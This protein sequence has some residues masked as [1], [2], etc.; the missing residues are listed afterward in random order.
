[1]YVPWVGLDIADLEGCVEAIYELAR[2]E[3]DDIELPSA[4]ARR[5][6][7][8][9][10]I[11]RVANLRE[12][13]SLGRVHG[14]HIIAVRRSHDRARAEH[15]IGHELGHW[16]FDR[17]GYEGDDLEACCDFIGAG[18]QT[19]RS[20]FQK[21]AGSRNWTQLALDFATTQTLVVLRYGEV[22]G[23]PLV[24]VTPQLV[25]VRG[26]EFAWPHEGELRRHAKAA[27]ELPGLAKTRLTDD[28]RRIA[29]VAE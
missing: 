26:D 25:R 12:N 10:A 13:A 1:M 20:V 21:H 11:V 28:R 2:L 16:Y 29:L 17:E 5:L 23:T 18:I 27:G 24:V 19:R 3:A 22:T 15:C 9:K 4:M 6:L 7:G 14:A 8:P